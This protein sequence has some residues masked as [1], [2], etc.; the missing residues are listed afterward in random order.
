MLVTILTP[1]YNRAY[2]LPRLFESLQKQT[3]KEFKWLVVDDGSSDDTEELIQQFNRTADFDIRY[4]YKE[5]G[6]RHSAINLGV[7]EIETALTF[8]VDSDDLL[9][10]NAVE[11]IIKYYDCYHANG[12]I[13]VFSF[14]R[15]NEK[16]EIEVPLPWDV[17]LSNYTTCRIKENRLGNMAEVFMTK[18]LCQ[19]PFPEFAGERFLSEDITWIEIAKEYQCLFVNTAIYQAEYLKDG[20]TRNDKKVKFAA[21][22]GSVLRG[23]Q[24][25]D[26]ACGWKTNVKGAIIYNC[27]LMEL[28]GDVPEILK[29]TT[30]HERVLLFATKP[31]GFLFHIKW[32][33][34]CS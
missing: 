7:R 9:L 20:L 31:L 12:K 33:S 34:Q 24:L 29:V 5:N 14:Q 10:P 28:D 13:G 22:K 11:E 6:G 17:K 26:L 2:S 32:K 16:G 21:P 18:V 23:K 15:C 1:A 30:V 3:C 4:I 19:Y 27:Y 8:P 25:M